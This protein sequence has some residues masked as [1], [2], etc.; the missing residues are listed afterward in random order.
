MEIG[1]EGG[2]REKWGKGRGEEG[3]ERER[4]GIGWE[5]LWVV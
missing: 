3:G 5:V 4:G 1:L 2:K